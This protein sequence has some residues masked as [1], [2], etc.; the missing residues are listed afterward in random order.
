MKNIDLD[1]LVSFADT[2]PD[3]HVNRQDDI[4]VYMKCLLDKPKKWHALLVNYPTEA[5]F[6]FSQNIFFVNQCESHEVHCEYSYAWQLAESR[7]Y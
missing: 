5:N 6:Y 1:R 7:R 3:Y 4:F 2:L